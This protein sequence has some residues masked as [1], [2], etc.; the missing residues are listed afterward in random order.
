[1]AEGLAPVLIE[2]AAFQGGMLEE[3]IEEKGS[4]LPPDELVLCRT[5]LGSRQA[6]WEVVE[7]QPGFTVTLRDTRT[8]DPVVVTERAASQTLHSGIYLLTASC[9]PDPESD[10]RR[11]IDDHV[12]PA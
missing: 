6:L 8:G 7:T 1:M 4:L 2:L 11:P 5:W 10:R 3:F 9:R 12:A